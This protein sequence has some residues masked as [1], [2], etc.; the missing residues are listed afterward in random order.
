MKKNIYIS[1]FNTNACSLNENFNDFQGL[2]SCSK[3]NFDITA[4]SETRITKQVS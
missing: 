2:L 3:N 4:I 1:L